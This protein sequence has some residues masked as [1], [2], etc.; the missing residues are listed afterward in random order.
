MG[1]IRSSAD[2]FDR[3]VDFTKYNFGIEN[4]WGNLTP[5]NRR[6]GGLAPSVDVSSILTPQDSV[7]DLVDAFASDSGSDEGNDNSSP[8]EGNSISAAMDNASQQSGV[9]NSVMNGLV[10]F[11]LN[12]VAPGVVGPIGLGTVASVAAR[13]ASMNMVDEMSTL[14]GLDPIADPMSFSKDAI[15]AAVSMTAPAVDTVTDQ[16]ADPDTS[17]GLSQAD[18]STFARDLASLMGLIGVAPAPNPAAKAGEEA[19]PSEVGVDPAP[20]PVGISDLGAFGPA[21]E[22]QAPG[23]MSES[24]SEGTEGGPANGPADSGQATGSM[25]ESAT[26]D[27]STSDSSTSDSSSDSSSDGS[28]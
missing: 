10:S 9:M 13:A 26:S 14:F 1:T 6:L 27:T 3:E 21:D 20:G 15:A 4:L 8:A 28:E 24:A 19:D 5:N 18:I 23:S 12:A 22:G 16:E 25:S 7:F 2:E 17:L 11:G